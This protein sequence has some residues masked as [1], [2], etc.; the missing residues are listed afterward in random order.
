MSAS[1]SQGEGQAMRRWDDQGHRQGGQEGRHDELGDWRRT[2]RKMTEMQ[3]RSTQGP[4]PHS[5]RALSDMD[6][7]EG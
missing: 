1:P 5:C 3:T 6:R 2:R 4:R 7:R